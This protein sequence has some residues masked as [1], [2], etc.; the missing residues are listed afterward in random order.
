MGCIATEKGGALL[1]SQLVAAVEN[2]G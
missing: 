1:G 2:S